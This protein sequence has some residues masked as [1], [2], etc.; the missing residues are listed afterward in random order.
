MT[1]ES[2][3]DIA[4]LIGSI[5]RRIREHEH[6]VTDAVRLSALEVMIVR[7]VH[8]HPDT[9]PS[10]LAHRLG[11]KS[12]NASAALRSLRQR[13]MIE[14]TSDPSDGRVVRLALTSRALESIGRVRSA[15][16]SYLA[17][18]LPPDRVSVLKDTLAEIEAAMDTALD[19]DGRRS[20]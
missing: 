11:L 2:I 14:R 9:T 7:D 19:A 15:S 17:T 8:L 16:A 1:D 5:G 12:S 3:A 10:A 13:G 20:D 6:A 18:F 4:A